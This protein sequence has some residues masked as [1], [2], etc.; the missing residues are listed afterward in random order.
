GQKRDSGHFDNL[1][2]IS[3]NITNS[4]TCAAKSSNQNFII[5]LSKNSDT[6]WMAQFGCL[7]ST[8]TFS[9]MIAF[10]WEAPPK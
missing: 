4:M 8:P 1:K 2:W 3:R 5:F 9:S 7:D 10:A 6:L